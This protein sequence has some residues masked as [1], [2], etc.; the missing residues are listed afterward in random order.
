MQIRD[1]LEKIAGMKLEHPE[2]EEWGDYAAFAG[3]DDRTDQLSEKLLK[4]DF[5]D[6]VTR[7]GG[8]MNIKLKDQYFV[9]LLT[10]VITDPDWG[11]AL[12]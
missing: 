9:T 11:K 5:V 10:E 6:S 7:V 2:R 8:F 1:K 3:S 12:L 4:L